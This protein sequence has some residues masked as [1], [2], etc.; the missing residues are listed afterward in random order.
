[1]ESGLITQWH[2]DKLLAGKYKGFF[3]GK[4][5]LLGHLGSG[6]MSSVYLA[7]HKISETI[8]SHQSATAKKSRGQKL[9]GSLLP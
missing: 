3:L 7:Q 4:Y 5:K 8:S 2:I 1:M 9:P 6:G